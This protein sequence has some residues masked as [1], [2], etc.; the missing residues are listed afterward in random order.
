MLVHASNIRRYVARLEHAKFRIKIRANM[1]RKSFLD[2]KCLCKNYSDIARLLLFSTSTILHIFSLDW[3]DS[4]L[5]QY[6]TD[7]HHVSLRHSLRSFVLAQLSRLRLRSANRQR[8]S[9]YALFSYS[10]SHVLP[11]LT[12]VYSPSAVTVATPLAAESRHSYPLYPPLADEPAAPMRT[13]AVYHGTSP[14]QLSVGAWLHKPLV[15]HQGGLLTFIE[16]A[17]DEAVIPISPPSRFSHTCLLH[18]DSAAHQV[19]LNSF[20]SGAA[21]PHGLPGRQIDAGLPGMV[22]DPEDLTARVELEG[23]VRMHYSPSCSRVCS[24]RSK[25]PTETMQDDQDAAAATTRSNALDLKDG[26]RQPEGEVSNEPRAF[27]VD[28]NV[29]A[30]REPV[31]VGKH[32]CCVVMK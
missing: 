30:S 25:G 24:P 3:S 11:L 28:F 7:L 27:D 20:S 2:Q 19:F 18:G 23:G 31:E 29:F 5:P 16:Q 10:T 21:R 15:I 14:D 13:S 12:V 22:E 1:S 32:S 6:S 9:M 26:E 17:D 4:F 8:C